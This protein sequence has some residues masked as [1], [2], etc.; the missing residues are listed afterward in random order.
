[1]FVQY[2]GE[3][4]ANLDNIC[5]ISLC[6]EYLTIYDIYQNYEN[7]KFD[8][9]ERAQKAYNKIVASLK[10]RGELIDLSE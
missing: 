6:E 9:S 4:L 5:T 10:N 3:E 8:T 2:D 1:M 7:I